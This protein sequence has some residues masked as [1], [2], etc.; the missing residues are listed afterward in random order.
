MQ[1]HLELNW[2]VCVQIRLCAEGAVEKEAAAE[3]VDAARVA[4]ETHASLAQQRSGSGTGEMLRSNFV[5]VA[6]LVLGQDGHL[7]SKEEQATTALFKARTSRAA[8]TFFLWRSSLSLSWLVHFKSRSRKAGDVDHPRIMFS[9]V[10][11]FCSA[12]A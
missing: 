3:G 12:Y 10:A 2:I 9:Y 8:N 4:A 11:L 5:V 6:D 1:R 7:L